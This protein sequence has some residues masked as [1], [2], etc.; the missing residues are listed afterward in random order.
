MPPKGRD[1]FGILEDESP[2]PS[3]DEPEPLSRSIFTEPTIKPFEGF[4]QEHL[5]ET[6]ATEPKQEQ[7][8]P[9]T[10]NTQDSYTTALVISEPLK[11]FYEELTE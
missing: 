9:D 6:L 5:R 11:H 3:D 8:T 7:R 2:S 4:D 10:V 1:F